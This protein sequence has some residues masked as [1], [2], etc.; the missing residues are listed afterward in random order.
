MGRKKIIV[1][2]C[3]LHVRQGTKCFVEGFCFVLFCFFDNCVRFL[4]FF[5][6]F[7]LTMEDL[8]VNTFY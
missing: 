5:L 3:Q 2:E 6:M 8:R 4:N 1:I 7:V